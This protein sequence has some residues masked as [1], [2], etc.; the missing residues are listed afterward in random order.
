MTSLVNSYFKKGVVSEQ[1]MVQKLWNEAI[2]IQGH[3]FYYLPRKLQKKD[4]L[5]GEDV[6]SAFEVALPIEMYIDNFN[7]WEGDQEIIS[8]FGLEIRKQMVLSVSRERWATEVAKISSNMWVSTRPQEGDLIYDPMT[9]ALLEIKQSDH[10]DEFYQLHK[11]YRYQLTCELFRYS[12]ESITT[13][14]ADID[15]ASSIDFMNYQL[16]N[17]DGTLMLLEEGYSIINDIGEEEP[18]NPR[19]DNT[20]DFAKES[21][22]IDFNVDNPFLE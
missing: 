7:N 3:T 8:K 12:Q 13:G 10:D 18:L 2:Q 19:S 11:N 14:I 4:N 9:R 20:F 22:F 6:L 17:E 21:V 5:F 15:V 16:L 1:N